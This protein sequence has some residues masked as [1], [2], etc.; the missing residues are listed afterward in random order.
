MQSWVFRHLRFLIKG[1]GFLPDSTFLSTT[2]LARKIT[3]EPTFTKKNHIFESNPSTP[4]LDFINPSLLPMD[5][6]GPRRRG[7]HSG[8][9]GDGT[10][11]LS[12]LE[13]SV[14]MRKKSLGRQKQNGPDLVDHESDYQPKDDLGAWETHSVRDGRNVGR[15][16]FGGGKQG[17]VL[18]GE[19][20]GWGP[21][22][23]STRRTSCPP[24]DNQHRPKERAGKRLA[25]LV[26]ES[27]AT[28]PHSVGLMPNGRPMDCA[29]S[30]CLHLQICYEEMLAHLKNVKPGQR[31]RQFELHL[32][33]TAE[34]LAR[35]EYALGQSRNNRRGMGAPAD[36]MCLNS[37]QSR[38]GGR[39]HPETSEGFHEYGYNG[40]NGGSKM[41][42]GGRQNEDDFPYGNRRGHFSG[43]PDD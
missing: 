40:K 15:D 8:T 35:M 16:D 43:F 5:S 41:S 9:H 22:A 10:N 14:I 29:E 19:D 39:G 31:R 7:G 32:E 25:K 28:D 34:E 36:D 1:R 33:E 24:E 6:L 11:R 12:D 17:P 26:E 18:A 21:H 27:E 37:H 42:R 23:T 4:S 20:F 13:D 2:I 30:Q 3:Q 38:A